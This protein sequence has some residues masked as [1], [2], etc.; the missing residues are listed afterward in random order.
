MCKLCS[1]HKAQ[2][3]CS[4][5]ECAKSIKKSG[6]KGGIKTTIC[7]IGPENEAENYGDKGRNGNQIECTIND[8]EAQTNN[9]LH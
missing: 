6:R 9:R 2:N 5:D 8:N 4:F 3:S 1:V 7:A